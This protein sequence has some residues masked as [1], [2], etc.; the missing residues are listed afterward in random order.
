MY[1]A[2]EIIVGDMHLFI[3]LLPLNIDHFDIILGMDWLQKYHATIDCVTKHVVFRPPG[4][5]EF[6]FNGRG[7]VPPPYLI[8]SVKAVKLIRKVCKG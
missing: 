4:L 5:P 1:P 7:V 6:V 8:S 3:D 2:C